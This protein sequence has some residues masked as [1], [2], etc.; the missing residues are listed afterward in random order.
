MRR[1]KKMRNSNIRDKQKRNGH[2]ELSDIY[3]KETKR[4]WIDRKKMLD[5][6]N[7]L[8]DKII[9]NINNGNKDKADRFLGYLLENQ[10]TEDEYLKKSLCDVSTK[11][12]NIEYKIKVLKLAYDIDNYDTVTLSS[13]ATALANSGESKKAFEYFKKSLE[14]NPD[15][16]VTLS[17]YATALANNGESEKSFEY[18][19][20]SLEIDSNN[21]VTLFSFGIFLKSIQDYP[22]AIE[23]F[24][25]ALSLD[26][27]LDST[28]DFL[29]L[30]LG[31]LYFYNGQ[32]TLGEK[33]FKLLID[34]S[35]NRD[36]A[37]IQS[38]LAIF[39]KNPYDER[40]VDKLLEVSY[41]E[42]SRF[43]KQAFGLLSISATQKQFYN[44]F[45]SNRNKNSNIINTTLELNRA[46]YHKIENQIS[47][48]RSLF[49]MTIK[50][51]SD[52]SRKEK[53]KKTQ[54]TVLEMFKI[55]KDKKDTEKETIELNK[56]DFDKLIDIIST[57]AHN[58]TDKISNKVFVIKSRL[59]RIEKNYP[60]IENQI[61]TTV[62]TLNNLKDL[63][64][65]SLMIKIE[66]FQLSELLK[67]LKHNM[68]LDNALINFEIIDGEINSD[69]Q[70]IT[71]CINEMIEN[72][73]RHNSKMDKINIF[74]ELKIV[75]NPMILTE[76]KEGDFL[77]IIYTDD[78][79]GIES[80]NKKWIF[81]PL[82]STMK[83]GSGLGLFI[84]K[85]IIEKLNGRVYEDGTDGARFNIYIPNIDK[86]N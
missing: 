50:R 22:K 24:K 51:E 65:G 6:A 19:K 44:F 37:L 27:L 83:N 54:I 70:K 77:N 85:R 72:S 32:K 15:N 25:K 23:I 63:K 34:N 75:Q 78:G 57:I 38:A 12:D 33:Q 47:I 30:A 62:A 21:I 68:Q 16:T 3:Q 67:N 61:K 53:L 41:I 8:K 42:D 79:K 52:E 9:V 66:R 11:I 69:K 49:D 40:G 73:I 82:N 64:Q 13:Y 29:Y 60:E 35:K 48:L 18:F 28:K 1:M 17:S 76:K 43:L 55:I 20:K 59:R 14:I 26:K 80:K 5:N 36:K 39:K 74:I 81:N 4:V 58:I 45:N 71:E 86:E 56:N 2:F 31:E 7:K 46:I 10:K 84:I